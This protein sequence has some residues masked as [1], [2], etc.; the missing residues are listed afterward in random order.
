MKHGI[1]NVCSLLTPEPDLRFADPDNTWFAND[2]KLLQN[3]IER[4]SKDRND[5]KLRIATSWDNGEPRLLVISVDVAE[6]KTVVA[7]KCMILKIQYMTVMV[8]L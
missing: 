4:Y 7:K 1:P 6:G 8:L 2:S 3:T 5:E